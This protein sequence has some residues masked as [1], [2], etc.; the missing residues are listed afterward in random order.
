[1]A[2]AFAVGCSSYSKLLKSE[3]SEAQYR[4]ALEYIETGKYQKALVLL[5]KV[6][7][8]FLNYHPERIDSLAFYSGLALYKSGDFESSG[9]VFDDFRKTYSHSPF[10]EEA[11]FMYAKGFYYMS[12]EPDRDQGATMQAMQAINE[13]IAR[14]PDS[15]KRESFQ[16]NFNELEQKL[17]DKAFL[18]AGTYYKIGRYRSAITALKNAR[19]LYPESNHREAILYMIAKSSYE[20]AHNSRADLRRDRYLNMM[21]EYLSYIAEYPEGQYVKELSKL[22]E[23]AKRY[24]ARFGDTDETFDTELE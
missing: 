21:D 15:P 8:P 1:M 9:M 2:A 14:Y 11:E 24:V 10:L 6:R 18:N 4:T 23:N 3:D 5:E 7:M 13:Y 17:H 16:D 12:P 19:D 20:Y 22:Q